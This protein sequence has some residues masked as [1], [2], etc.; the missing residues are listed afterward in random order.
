MILLRPLLIAVCAP[1]LALSS[2]A[3]AG[4]VVQLVSEPMSH[5]PTIT[6]ADLFDGAVGPSGTVA[7]APAAREGG[8]AVLDASRVQLLAHGAGLDWVNERGLRRVI[9]TAGALDSPAATPVV[10]SRPAHHVAARTEPVEAGVKAVVYARNIPTGD[11]IG[12]DDLVWADLPASTRLSDPVEDAYLA[13]G[14]VARHPIRAGA[15]AS[16]HDLAGAKVVHRDDMI[17]V[18][19]HDDGLTL[20][21]QGRAQ[22]DAAVGDSV[23]VINSVSKKIVEAVVSGP[24]HAVVGPDAEALRSQSLSPVRYAAAR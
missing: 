19:F 10:P 17:V 22:A 20:T 18:T 9:V 13:T 7:V 11:V 15:V 3:S 8:Q 4:V 12:P 16:M 23:Q 24:G 21:L 5:G 2:A 1:V 6:L 14:M